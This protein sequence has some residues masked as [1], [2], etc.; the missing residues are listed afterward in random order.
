MNFIKNPQGA[1]LWLR[2]KSKF[3][4]DG[5]FKRVK[6]WY[7]FYCDH[8]FCDKEYRLAKKQCAKYIESGYEWVI[9]LDIREI[10]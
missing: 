8:T 4:G 2:E 6:M 7:S 9:E 1:G 10:R 5:F 3:I